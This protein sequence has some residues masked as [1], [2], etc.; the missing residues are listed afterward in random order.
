L[1]DSDDDSSV[2]EDFRIPEEI[3]IEESENKD[4]DNAQ[5]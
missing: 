1:F 4:S 2:I 5:D 3:A